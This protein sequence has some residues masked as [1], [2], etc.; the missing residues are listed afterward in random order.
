MLVAFLIVSTRLWPAATKRSGAKS[1]D[2]SWTGKLNTQAASV[3]NTYA[4]HTQ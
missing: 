2:P 3:R 1:V 4:I